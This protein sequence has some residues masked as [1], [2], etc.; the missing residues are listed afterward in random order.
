M[1][2][3]RVG[4]LQGTGDRWEP[5]R[6]VD[7]DGVVVGQFDSTACNSSHISRIVQT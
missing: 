7:S 2:V 3:A 6:L 4:S 1:V 5:Y